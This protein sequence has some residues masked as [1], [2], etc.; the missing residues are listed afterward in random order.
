MSIIKISIAAICFACLLFLSNCKEKEPPPNP[1]ASKTLPTGNFMLAEKLDG[2]ERYFETDKINYIN[3]LFLRGPEGYDEYLWQVGTNMN[4]STKQNAKVSF[5]KAEGMLK[6]RLVGKRKP[7]TDCYPGD[8]GVDTVEKWIDVVQ[9]SSSTFWIS[10]ILG[11]WEGK[12]TQFGDTLYTIRFYSIDSAA[13]TGTQDGFLEYYSKNIL[14]NGCGSTY[15]DNPGYIVWEGMGRTSGCVFNHVAYTFTSN[16]DSIV[17][18]YEVQG[19]PPTYK[20]IPYTFKGKR[21]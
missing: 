1:C 19:P 6:I 15:S 12:S 20:W 13:G 2:K 11:Y 8:D 16:K 17:V 7:M 3:D 4:W 18:E 10:P 21:K 9:G 14:K 5:T